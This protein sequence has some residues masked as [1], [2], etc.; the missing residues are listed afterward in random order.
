[1]F[2]W[3]FTNKVGTVLEATRYQ[4]TDQQGIGNSVT[5]TRG[6]TRARIK[7]DETGN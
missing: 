2:K 1:M 5:V 4:S 7:W 3:E 6:F